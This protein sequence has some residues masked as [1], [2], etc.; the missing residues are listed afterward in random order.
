VLRKTFGIRNPGLVDTL[1]QA[2]VVHW[3][4]EPDLSLTGFDLVA[5]APIILSVLNLVIQDELV[6]PGNDVEI[7]L[8]GNI[9]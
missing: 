7:T 4:R 9:I 1:T 5:I 2:L 3:N 8:P 6:D